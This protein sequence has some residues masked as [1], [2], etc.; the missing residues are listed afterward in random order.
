MCDI[1]LGHSS[2]YITEDGCLNFLDMSS[3]KQAE[4]TELNWEM[5]LLRE[6]SFCP[7][8]GRSP[9]LSEFETMFGSLFIFMI[10]RCSHT[11]NTNNIY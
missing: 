7:K 8:V 1:Y 9:L 2:R 4:Q 5:Q 10:L 6:I 11:C 3:I